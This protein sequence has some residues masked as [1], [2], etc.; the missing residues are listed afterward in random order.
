MVWLRVSDDYYDHRKFAELSPL[1]ISAWLAGLAYAN[2]NLT[3][4]TLPHRVPATLVDYTGLRIATTGN[5]SRPATAADAVSEIVHAGLW[6]DHG[7]TCPTCPQPSPREYVIHDYLAYQPSRATVQ[8]GRDE[9]RERSRRA[10]ARRVALDEP[11]AEPADALSPF[12]AAM[13]SRLGLGNVRALVRQVAAHTGDQISP[14]RA[15][16][17]ASVI[18]ERAKTPPRAPE[19]YVLAAIA[20]APAEISQILTGDVA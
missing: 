14:D 1:G 10:R 13:S 7:H 20:R 16:L 2:R 15:V 18:L 8:H 12:M 5:R 4:G 17:L 6:H 19:R 3:D 11:A 9:S